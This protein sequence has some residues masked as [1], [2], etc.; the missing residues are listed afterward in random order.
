M[1]ELKSLQK[2]PKVGVFG[3]Q[4]GFYRQK[5]FTGLGPEVAKLICLKEEDKNRQKCSQIF[6]SALFLVVMGITTSAHLDS[7]QTVNIQKVFIL[8]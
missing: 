7:V 1:V 4:Y 8:T 3:Q 6:I 5:T 2:H